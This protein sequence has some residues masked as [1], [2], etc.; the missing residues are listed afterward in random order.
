M[1]LRF[2]DGFD[3][4]TTS[5]S[6]LLKWTAV[7]SGSSF[8]A[9]GRRS[10][11]LAASFP[12]SNGSYISK[13]LNDQNTWIVGGAFYFTNFGGNYPFMK[14]IDNTSSI[15]CTVHITS[16]Q[17]V[18]IYR[19]DGSTL[20]GTSSATIPMNAWVY[21]EIKLFINDTTGTFEVLLGGA[22]ILS[23]SG[24]TKSSSTLSTAQTISIGNYGTNAR[25]NFYLDDFY[26]CDGTGSTNNTFLGD[27]RVDTIYPTG[28]GASGQFTGVGDTANLYANVDDPTPDGDSTYNY[29]NTA[30]NNDSFVCG[31]ITAL[32]STIYG[33]QTN[34]IARK[35][36]AGTR[37][38]AAQSRVSGTSYAGSTQS[39]ADSYVDLTQIWE[40]NPATSTAWTEAAINDAEFGYKVIA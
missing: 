8:N 31:D 7:N 1:A 30:G 27:V 21:L 17:Q 36:D 23:Y 6:A 20:L 37:T 19:G 33:V 39:L 40:I 38:M 5:A 2:I 14:F 29:S 25:P 15:Q 16:A 18:S 34:L 26:I 3:H 13:T 11:S 28:A 10:G 9:T 22:S 24:D 4:Y 12:Y 35:D 32:S